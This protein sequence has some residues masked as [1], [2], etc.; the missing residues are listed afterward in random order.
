MIWTITRR[1]RRQILDV[2]PHPDGNVLLLGDG[3][4]ITLTRQELADE[5]ANGNPHR[6][7]RDHHVTCPQA[8]TVWG[9]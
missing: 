4:S 6:L 9:R 7:H 5:A 3:G 2:E 1:G 8:R